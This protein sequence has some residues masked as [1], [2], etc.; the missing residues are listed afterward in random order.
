M[1]YYEAQNAMGV[2]EHF[3]RANQSVLS[4]HEIKG[5][6]HLWNEHWP[7]TVSPMLPLTCQP[8]SVYRRGEITLNDKMSVIILCLW[9]THSRDW[10]WHF[11]PHT[12]EQRAKKQNPTMAHFSVAYLCSAKWFPPDLTMTARETLFLKL[13]L[14]NLTV[15]L[16]ILY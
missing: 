4:H 13:L 8:S 3:C 14:I 6:N 11:P 1:G 2:N 12:A 9:C 7:Y 15:I 16:N 5:E 10:K